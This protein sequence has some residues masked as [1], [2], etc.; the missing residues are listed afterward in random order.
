MCCSLFFSFS[1]QAKIS[2]PFSFNGFSWKYIYEGSL[3]CRILSFSGLLKKRVPR[4]NAQ[5]SPV[6]GLIILYPTAIAAHLKMAYQGYGYQMALLSDCITKGRFI[7]AS[8]IFCP[9]NQLC[10]TMVQDDEC[11]RPET[12][13]F[14]TWFYKINIRLNITITGYNI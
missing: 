1:I 10:L 7:M 2:I 14:V 11:T 5:H 9:D 13:S 12:G 6:M 3:I 4:F 8:Y